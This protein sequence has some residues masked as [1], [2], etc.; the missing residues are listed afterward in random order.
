MRLVLKTGD[1]FLV[2]LPDHEKRYFQ[3][4]GNDQVQLNSDLIRVFIKTDNTCISL[5][6]IVGS[7]IDFHAHVSIRLGFKM[8]CWSKIG[9][10]PIAAA[11]APLFRTSDD[12]G[13]P[14][15][16]NSSKWSVWYPNEERVYV[17][18]LPLEYQSAE[19]GVVVA[20]M[21]IVERITKGK[22]N[23]FYPGYD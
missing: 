12:Y 6:D 1:I 14:E 23:F 13:N 18:K 19:I 3:Y 15:V 16:K 21:F 22:Y 8:S 10:A 11:A 2:H 4:I 9:N 17:G 20:P 5:E 7:S